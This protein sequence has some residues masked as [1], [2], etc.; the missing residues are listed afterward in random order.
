MNPD[1]PMPKETH[2]NPNP[3]S[4]PPTGSVIHNPDCDVND[5]N[6]D[7]IKKP[8]NCGVAPKCAVQLCGSTAVCEMAVAGEW[9]PIC[10]AH[11]INRITPRRPLSSP[12]ELGQARWA[13]DSGG[14]RRRNP[15][16]PA[17]RG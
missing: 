10:Q 4:A 15:A 2:K 11:S 7:G 8:C 5:I 13:T 12:N 3:P 14:H 6:P 9:F 1:K 16:S 17:P